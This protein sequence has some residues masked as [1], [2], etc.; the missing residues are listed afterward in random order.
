[1]KSSAIV[2]IVIWSVVAVILCGLLMWGLV[3]H[4]GFE[5]H[6]PWVSGGSMEGYTYGGTSFDAS[7]IDEV[8]V[9]WVSGDMTIREGSE[10]SFEETSGSRLNEDEQLVYKVDGRRLIIQE[11]RRSFW[12]GSTPS[13]DLTLELPKKLK[14]LTVEIVSADVTMQGTF[15]IDEM[16]LEGVSGDWEVDEVSCQ[17]ISLETV[18]G[19]MN[20][21]VQEPPREI[22]A[23]TVSGDINLYLPESAGFSAEVDGV[24]GDLTS[25]FP[26]TSEKGRHVYGSGY[27]EID[28]DTVSGDLVIRKR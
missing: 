10:I 2:R 28:L 16:D 11:Y 23:D 17:E 19:N 3:G 7:E 1:M 13:K 25:E 5:F 14:R 8:Q 15:A 20:V 6:L 4:Y 9:E 18:S 22:D 24:S 12:L 27:T 21:T 26:V